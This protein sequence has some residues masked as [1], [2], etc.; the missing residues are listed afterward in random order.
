MEP[1]ANGRYLLGIAG[2]EL[3]SSGRSLRQ[4]EGHWPPRP[5]PD[6]RVVAPLAPRAAVCGCTPLDYRTPLE[7]T[8]YQTAATSA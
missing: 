8:D 5:W 3:G 4:L 7:L 2:G 1:G 6:G